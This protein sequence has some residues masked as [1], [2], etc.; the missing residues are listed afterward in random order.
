MKTKEDNKPTLDK[1]VSYYSS[2]K[3][4]G[5]VQVLMVSTIMGVLLIPVFLLFLVPMS[6][7]MMAFTSTIFIFLFAIIM[8]VVA[9]GRTYEVFVGTAT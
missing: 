2:S 6:R 3:L 8:T 7:L 4:H 1:T 9:E 5:V